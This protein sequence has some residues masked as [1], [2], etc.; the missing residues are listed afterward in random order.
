MLIKGGGR[1]RRRKL[2][3]RVGDVKRDVSLHWMSDVVLAAP[4]S[5]LLFADSFR[6]IMPI[7]Y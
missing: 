4:I 3:D 5:S 2:T 6:G 1:H 7:G